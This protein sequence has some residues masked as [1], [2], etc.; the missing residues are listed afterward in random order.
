M[1]GRQ[2]ADPLSPSPWDR[3]AP[4][5]PSLRAGRAPDDSPRRLLTRS[6]RPGRTACPGTPVD[7]ARQGSPSDWRTCSET[8]SRMANV[9]GEVLTAI[10]TPFDKDGVV[11]YDRF[12]ALAR[13]VIDSGGGRARPSPQP[14]VSLR[15]S[16]TTRKAR[17]LGCVSRRGRR[18]RNR[19][20]KHRHLLDRALGSPDR[21]GP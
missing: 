21:A 14:R 15:R 12:R 2:R 17:A 7:P 9:L 3:R 13:H 5:S 1:N 6:V 20:R 11:D 10:V 16:R 4:G 8:R 19:H 18:A